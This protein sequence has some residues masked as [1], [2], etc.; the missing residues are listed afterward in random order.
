MSS[1]YIYG[2]VFNNR[3]RIERNIKDISKL[4]DKKIVVVD[5]YS[6]DGTYEYLK[7][8]PNV[9]VIQKKCTRGLGRDIALKR[10]YS[11]YNPR[12]DDFIMYNDFDLWYKDEFSNLLSR[13]MK[14]MNQNEMF[15]M[16]GGL[17]TA[18]TQENLGWKDLNYGEDIERL[19]RAKSRGIKI[20]GFEYMKDIMKSDEN[21]NMQLNQD[22]IYM[23]NDSK[24]GSMIERE[25]RYHKNIITLGI[26]LI[27]DQ[28]DSCRG[29][30]FQSWKDLCIEFEKK[31]GKHLIYRIM[32][33][34]I[35]MEAK[36]KG[37]YNYSKG[38]NNW[39]YIKGD[40]K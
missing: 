37:C 2:T 1:L 23:E 35:Y 30:N 27:K 16:H 8:L 32:F 20:I 33:F 38:M 29:W 19:A 11:I 22:T 7:S 10:I 6:T 17:S 36:I 13:L 21:D 14:T 25:K 24:F 12:P 39:Q 18:H 40:D 34:M 4:T 28:I 15:V 26:R 3:D 31:H 5:N 9:D